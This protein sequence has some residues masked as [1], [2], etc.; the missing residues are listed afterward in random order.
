MLKSTSCHGLTQWSFLFITCTCCALVSF[1]WQRIIWL[2]GKD[3]E[4]RNERFKVCQRSETKPW[5][6]SDAAWHASWCFNSVIS[7]SRI[8]LSSDYGFCTTW[9]GTKDTLSPARQDCRLSSLVLAVQ[10]ASC[11]PA[12]Y[13]RLKMGLSTALYAATAVLIIYLYSTEYTNVR[14][15]L[16]GGRFWIFL[17]QHDCCSSMRQRLWEIRRLS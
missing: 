9:E 13:L 3:E 12:F 1:V 11:K 15:P 16:L 7:L 2:A 4:R 14:A 8:N 17:V 5:Q 10:I 6:S